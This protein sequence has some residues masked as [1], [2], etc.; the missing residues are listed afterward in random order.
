VITGKEAVKIKK[1]EKLNPFLITAFSENFVLPTYSPEEIPVREIS[2]PVRDDLKLLG[3]ENFYKGFISG[4]IGLYS[5]PDLNVLY[6]SPIQNGIFRTKVNGIYNRPFVDNSDNYKLK[7]GADLIYWTDINSSFLPGTQFRLNADLMN[8][9]YK[10]YGSNNSSEKRSINSLFADLNITNEYNSSFLFKINFSDRFTSLSG[11]KFNENLIDLNF[12]SMLRINLFKLGLY[13]NLKNVSISNDI[14]EHPQRN[15]FLVRPTA[16]FQFTE[17]LKGSFGF[18]ISQSSMEKFLMPYA[19]LA[20]KL[21][22]NFTFLGE[23]NP[24]TEFLTPASLLEKNP[25]YKVVNSSNLLIKKSMQYMMS[26]KYEYQKYFDMTFGVKYFGT[27]SLPYFTEYSKG[28]Y[29]LEFSDVKSFSPFVNFNFFPS[30]Y[31]FFFSSLE[32]NATQN[33][34]GQTLPY[35]PFIRLSANY[36]Y[37][38]SEVFTTILS[39][40]YSGRQYTDLN[41]SNEIKNYVNLGLSLSYYFDKRFDFF[42]KFDNLLNNKNF[43]WNNYEGKPFDILIGVKYKL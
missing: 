3:M 9:G 11:E 43:I 38:F 30:I 17:L 28:K 20:L 31:G 37:I 5:L 19:E 35:T 39:L 21:A 32:L 36:G 40:D 16:G 24:S 1:S 29:E 4:A 26:V 12:N 34:S 14:S 18:T 33:D 7:A 15:Y 42:V 8:N 27:D 13:A 41:N 22:Q 23:F 2:L 25:Y 6:A 10:F